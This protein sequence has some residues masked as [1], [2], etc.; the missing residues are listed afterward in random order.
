MPVYLCV[1]SKA[2]LE[3]SGTK[4]G[5]LYECGGLAPY[6]YRGLPCSRLKDQL[7]TDAAAVTPVVLGLVHRSSWRSRRLTRSKGQCSLLNAPGWHAGTKA[8]SQMTSAHAMPQ[9]CCGVAH[10]HLDQAVL[11]V[12]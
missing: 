1:P 12:S 4:G 8:T 5:G 6:A 10:T 2:P 9:T 7:S 3:I 11:A